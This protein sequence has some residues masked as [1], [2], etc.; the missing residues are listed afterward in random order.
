M[1]AES[2]NWSPSDYAAWWGA[3]IASVALGW[4]IVTQIRS[5]PRIDLFVTPGMIMMPP[6]PLTKDRS[7]VRFTATN[8]G[9]APLTITSICGIHTKRSLPVFKG[10]I[11]HFVLQTEKHLSQDL[12]KLLSPG[13]EWNALVDQKG[14]EDMFPDGSL[15]VGIVHN[16]RKQ[17]MYRKVKIGAKKSL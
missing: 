16:R 9:T 5:G 10:K 6:S 3:A 15:Y 11:T 14:I 2:L 1:P 12:P 8:S 7:F 4:N 17:P 13:E